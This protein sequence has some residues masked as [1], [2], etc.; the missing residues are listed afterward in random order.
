MTTRALILTVLV[1]ASPATAAEK[2]DPEKLDR[3]A[4]AAQAAIKRGDCPGAVVLVLHGDAVVYRKAFGNGRLS[5]EP[6]PM[7]VD[8]VFDMA[9]LTKPVA[10]ATAIILLHERGKIAFT[11]TVGK[12]WPEFAANGKETVTVEH[13]L[14]HTSGL[15]AD[16]AVADYRMGKAEAL[17][18]IAAL[19]LEQ[20]PGEKFKYSDVGFITLG[21][22]VEKITGELLDVFTRKNIFEPLGMKDSGFLPSKELQA[23]AV[24]TA[25]VGDEWLQGRVHDPR[26]SA[27]GGGAGHAGLFSTADDMAIYAKMLLNGGKH[28]GKPFLSEKSVTAMTEPLSVPGGARS[29]GWDVDTAYSAPRGNLFGKRDG[30]GHT[31]FTGTSLWIDRPSKTAIV[32]LTSRLQIS[33]KAQVTALRRQIA[34]VVAE[35][36][37][38][39]PAPKSP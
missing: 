8:G 25:K 28:A 24:P 33:E 22:V 21:V 26:A 3:I 10:T 20:P 11:D 13:L 38:K 32:I 29:R 7:A 4:D 12:H 6:L 34:D 2:F 18:R 17:K 23:M 15:L 39:T 36:V 31:G 27:L 14:T 37:G 30:F 1:L 5:P 16:N 35:A 19:K 9:S